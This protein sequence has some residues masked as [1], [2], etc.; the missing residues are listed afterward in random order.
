MVNRVLVGSLLGVIALLVVVIVVMRTGGDEEPVAAAPGATPA[1]TPP[2]QAVSPSPSPVPWTEGDCLDV[3]AL[4]G[5]SLA[6]SS[7]GSPE[8]VRQVRCEQ[9][10]AR[11]LRLVDRGDGEQR[12]PRDTDGFVDTPAGLGEPRTACVRN[13]ADPHPAARGKGGGVLVAG[14]C[15]LVSDEGDVRER[16]CADAR[17]PGRVWGLYKKKSQCKDSRGFLDYHYAHRRTH[18][19]HPVVCAGPGDTAT[20]LGA[21]YDNGTCFRK[22]AT[23]STQLGGL[24]FGGLDEVSCSSRSAWAEVVASARVAEDCPARSTRSVSDDHHYP[25]TTCLRTLR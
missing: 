22:P 4:A 3:T 13:L 8:T 25:G 10:G 15:V 1:V 17:G 20:E 23:L 2:S 24:I 7:G 19:T 14:D 18:P 6:P 12:C 5:G 21:K 16:A 9:G 11:I